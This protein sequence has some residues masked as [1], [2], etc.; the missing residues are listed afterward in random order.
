MPIKPPF[1]W[2]RAAGRY[3]GPTG[4]FVPTARVREYLDTALESAGARMDALANGLRDGS[5]DL[6]S[7]EVR[8][9]REVKIVATYSGAAAK[10]GWAQMTEA[11][12]GRVGRYLQDQYK[13]LRGFARDVQTGAQPMNGMV[14]ARSRLYSEAGRPLY[15][16]ME[17]AEVLVRGNTQRMS[18]RHGRDSCGGCVS[19]ERAGWHDILGSTV[20]E[21]GERECRTRCRCSWAYR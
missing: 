16:R 4:A 10:G 12:Y 14:N 11:D 19:A 6:I 13:Y 17:K 18:I 1:R 9:R 21:I 2:D 5:I 3:R 20:T 15:H 8:M 7:W